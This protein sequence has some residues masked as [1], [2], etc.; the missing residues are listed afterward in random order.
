MKALLVSMLLLIN[1]I[2]CAIAKIIDV[3][4]H[5]SFDYHQR[6]LNVTYHNQHCEFTCTTECKEL[7]IKQCNSH[8]I[9]KHVIFEIP[10]WIQLIPL[11]CSELCQFNCTQSMANYHKMKGFKKTK[12]NGHWIFTR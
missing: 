10:G 7:C 1:I 2:C 3:K 9:E 4:E 12:Y 6:P 5:V 11:S 8:K